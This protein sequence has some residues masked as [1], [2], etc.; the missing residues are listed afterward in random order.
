MDMELKLDEWRKIDIQGLL[1]NF[2][3]SKT[4]QTE[5]KQVELKAPDTVPHTSSEGN[6]FV[7]A[8]SE[9]EQMFQENTPREV[10]WQRILSL[11]SWIEMFFVKSD[12]SASVMYSSDINQLQKQVLVIRNELLYER[13]A[14][15]QMEQQMQHINKSNVDEWE[16]SIQV[17][18][19]NLKVK[20]QKQEISK[21]KDEILALRQQEKQ[22]KNRLNNSDVRTNSS[23]QDNIAV[24]AKLKEENTLLKE[25]IDQLQHQN[26]Q[27]KKDVESKAIKIF[28]LETR[29]TENASRLQKLKQTELKIEHLQEEV[30]MW[31]RSHSKWM[32]T[33]KQNKQL[34]DG[35]SLRDKMIN[36]LYAKHE[37]TTDKMR[38]LSLS[39]HSAYVY[40]YY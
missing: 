33:A 29:V 23:L 10:W 8:Y 15:Q 19:L 5:S 39:L 38:Q 16:S 7:A 22:H 2:Q 1:C 20:Q 13:V 28:E 37:I 40:K 24:S 4:T 9:L 17:D 11:Q 3:L 32:N 27:L 34:V 12:P 14:R 21:L 25:S 6:S 30:F 35:L 31:E 26:S 18:A 36:A